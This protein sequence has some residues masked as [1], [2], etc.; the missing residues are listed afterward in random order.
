MGISWRSHKKKRGNATSIIPEASTISTEQT[1]PID[2]YHRTEIPGAEL[3]LLLKLCIQNIKLRGLTIPLLFLPFRPGSTSATVEPF[4][5]DYFNG[6]ASQKGTEQ[7]FLITEPLVLVGVLRWAYS[8]IKGGILSF[9][10]YELFAKTEKE[11]SY[12]EDAFS[13]IVGVLIE[14][15]VRRTIFCDFLGLIAAIASNVKTNGHSAQRLAQASASLVFHCQINAAGQTFN[16]GLEYWQKAAAAVE[17]LF[18]AYL[19]DMNSKSS[20]GIPSLPTVLSVLLANTAYPPDEKDPT[21]L[22][23]LKLTITATGISASPTDLLKRAILHRSEVRSAA[24]DLLSAEGDRMNL[25]EDCYH[26]IK[27]I[28]AV[29]SKHSERIANNAV[30]AAWLDFQVCHG[31]PIA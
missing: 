24:L 27:A 18:W 20:A 8:R 2:H 10:E 25:A 15:D 22:A 29:H 23:A 31:L 30:D 26:T 17:H 11:L 3:V 21:T 16:T 6:A 14:S 4:V 9:S 13:H 19:R 12:A 1:T 7:L 5:R 28:E